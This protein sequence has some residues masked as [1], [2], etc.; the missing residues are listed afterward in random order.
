MDLAYRPSPGV[1]L[2]RERRRPPRE[3]RPR[4]ERPRRPAE[5]H[6]PPAPPHTGRPERPG[7]PHRPPA[8]SRPVPGPGSMDL[9][10]VLLIGILY[11]LY[12]ESRDEEFLIVLIIMA[13]HIFGIDLGL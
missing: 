12:R 3:E 1:S 5:P 2:D 4:P 13:L 11:L 8:P 7:P 9:S 10:D 6:R